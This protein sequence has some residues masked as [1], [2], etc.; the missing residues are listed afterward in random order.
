MNYNMNKLEKHEA[1]AF[2]FGSVSVTML[3]L[4]KFLRL[5]TATLCRFDLALPVSLLTNYSEDIVLL[6][7]QIPQ[8]TCLFPRF[9]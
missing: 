1:R 3:L 9:S 4:W 5:S 8:T 7:N 6:A 2:S